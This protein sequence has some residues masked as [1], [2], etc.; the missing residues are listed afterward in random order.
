MLAKMTSKNQITIPKKIIEQLPDV[1]YFE[2]E[3][4]DGIV[5]L[6]PLKTYDTSMER[7]R[8]KVKKLGLQEN[9]VKEAIEWAR[10]K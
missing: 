3:L 7:I 6:K 10:S 4:K 5:M 1:E 9:T 2:V 8:T